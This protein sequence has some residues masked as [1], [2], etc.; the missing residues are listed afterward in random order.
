MHVV[1]KLCHSKGG[2]VGGGL[3]FFSGWMNV[4]MCVTARGYQCPIPMPN[5]SRFNT[6]RDLLSKYC[7]SGA[8]R[9]NVSLH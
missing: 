1:I 3:F 9:A 7:H 8:E 4:S 5:V 6:A 2:G